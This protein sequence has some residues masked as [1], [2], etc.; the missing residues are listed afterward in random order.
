MVAISHHLLSCACV[1]GASVDSLTV[2]AES[3]EEEDEGGVPAL[4]KRSSQVN[5]D[6]SLPDKPRT[7]ISRDPTPFPKELHTKA[8]Q[9][10]AAREVAATG[11]GG[12]AH[13][14]SG[15]ALRPKGAGGRRVQ[16]RNSLLTALANPLNE[17]QIH[18]LA[19]PSLQSNIS[20]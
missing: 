7:K 9:W 18:Q 10:R 19:T 12:V 8:M 2:G 17:V 15:V 4:G 11:G 13:G 1:A 6:I 5:F 20:F 16:D 14:Q 3:G